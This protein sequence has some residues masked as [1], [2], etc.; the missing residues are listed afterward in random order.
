MAAYLLQPLRTHAVATGP[1]RLGGAYQR[2]LGWTLDHRKT[3]LSLVA[4]IFA[5]SVALL[6]LL[7]TGFLPSSDSN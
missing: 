4:M 7:P 5:G 1:G 3:A 6:T 2:L